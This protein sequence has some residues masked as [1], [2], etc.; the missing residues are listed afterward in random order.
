MGNLG[1]SGGC[2]GYFL[3]T[4]LAFFCGRA[5]DAVILGLNSAGDYVGHSNGTRAP[6]DS[7]PA[8]FREPRCSEDLKLRI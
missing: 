4:L 1:D 7:C 2:P 5:E 8:M 3:P 6:L